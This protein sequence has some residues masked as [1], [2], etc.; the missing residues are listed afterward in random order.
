MRAFFVIIF[1]LINCFI[2]LA[3]NIDYTTRI[4]RFYAGNCSTEFGTEE[5]T[6]QGW[7]SD[8]VNTAETYS[9]CIQRNYNGSVIQSGSYAL[10]TRNNTNAT[11]LRARIDA[12]EDD[13][14]S[15][16]MYDPGNIFTGGDDCRVSQIS[17]FNFTN[18]LEYQYINNTVTVGTG[19]Y[20]MS[21][22]YQYRYSMT[23]LPAATEYNVTNLIT[24]GTRP[25][26]GCR[27]NWAAVGSDC[28]ASGTIGN[29]Q[30]SS[31]T[32]TVSCQSQVSFRWR[33]SSEANYDFLKVYV[34]GVERTSISG[35]VGWTLVTLPLD[36]GNNTVEWRY[37]KDGSVSSGLDRGFIDD[38]SFTNATSVDPGSV[39][40]GETFNII[41]NPGN[42]V[43]VANG[44]A[45]S[46][47]LNYQWQYSNDGIT[48]WFNIGG[49]TGSSYNPPADLTTTRYYRR[50]IQDQ[51]GNLDYSNILQVEI[52]PQFV[53]DSGYWDP[54]DPGTTSFPS[55]TTHSVIIREN[56][57]QTNSFLTGNLIIDPGAS[58]TVSGDIGLSVFYQVELNGILDLGENGQLIQSNSSAL[59]LGANGALRKTRNGNPNLYR[60]TYWGSPV[61]NP[62]ATANSGHNIS[63]VMNDGTTGIPRP[64]NFTASNVNDGIPGDISTPAT[65]SSKW[66]Y[67]FRNL[68]NDY[69][70]WEQITPG[71]ILSSGQGFTM[72]GTQ[73][74]TG[75][76]PFIFVGTPNNGDITLGIT[77]N[78]NY[79]IS[80][81][82]PSAIDSHRFL[83][84]NPD[85]DGT[86]Y[87][88]EHYGG[89]THI[90]S[91]YQG[92]YA[93]YNFSGGVG[94]PSIASPDPEVSGDGTPVKIP[95]RYIPV[96][97]G[98][99]VEAT[100]TG[101]FTFGNNQR[102]Y[103]SELPT[104]SVFVR[105]A[106]A[107]SS[108][109]VQPDNRTKI[110]L[111]MTSPDFGHRQLLLTVDPA[112][113]YGVDKYYDGP[114]FEV[115][116]N[117][118]AF[119]LNNGHYGIQG[120]PSIN[121]N[122][123]I[124]L[125]IDITDTG[126][127]NIG[128]D[129][130]ENWDEDQN[131]YLYDSASAIYY[132]LR[133]ADANISLTNNQYIGR[134]SLRFNNSTLS[135]T[136]NEAIEDVLS[137][138]QPKNR[139]RIVIQLS[140]QGY[141]LEKVNL[142]NVNG[143]VILNAKSN[144]L[145]N[146]DNQWLVSTDGLSSGAYILQMKINGTYHTRK[147]IIK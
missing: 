100:T 29:N 19:D 108:E 11:Q 128:L 67:A 50:R 82:Y 24:G 70:N 39:T 13:T 79:L 123:D 2:S 33:V 45:Y 81:P 119:F 98:F 115:L 107:T 4:V 71:T 74:A 68:T 122:D 133:V 8:N 34:N 94:A 21:V 145:L 84:D 72:K 130:L 118:F 126:L 23:T 36:Y 31:F 105:S 7:L 64:L 51:C 142:I 106:N 113:S 131:I 87:F 60:Y 129:E 54:Y 56:T 12:W 112:A 110:R 42:L 137:V 90:L 77:A 103:V 41:G 63:S 80:N 92:G 49:A 44:Q 16:C 15:R 59:I 25:F 76:Q 17:Y 62:G 47:S 101:S 10:R 127:Y 26:W 96:A 89:D 109:N 48:S 104:Q 9:G 1:I 20:N 85:L 18:P 120:I 75:T 93:T 43:N 58:L 73:T 88:W 147:L 138:Y 66:L 102:A 91:G 28:A 140:S 32:T 146:R 114:S 14:G 125:V 55:N 121:L 141:R 57:T 139:N 97:Q 144:V 78:N 99:F 86:L 52:L 135:A 40:G 35:T 3:Q 124:P 30:T 116:P 65:I 69:S 38:I 5:H 46:A 37:E 22:F 117:D 136:I 111:G 53:Y 134:F 83:L 27:G 132:D 61:S 6:W 143:R 95:G